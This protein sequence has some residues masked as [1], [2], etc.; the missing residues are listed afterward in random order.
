KAVP[1]A[2]ERG[3]GR[4]GRRR[5]LVRPGGP[6]LG[7]PRRARQGHVLPGLRGE[8]GLEPVA[9]A[10]PRRR[11]DRAPRGDQLLDHPAH[12]QA[13]HRGRGRRVHVQDRQRHGAA[14]PAH[15]RP[16]GWWRGLHPRAGAGRHREAHALRVVARQQ[17]ELS[18]PGSGSRRGPEVGAVG[19]QLGVDLGTTA[20]AA[21]VGRDG[22]TEVVNLGSRSA[23]VPAVVFARHDGVLTFGESAEAAGASEPAR[24]QRGLKRRFGDPAPVVVGD[25]VSTPE[26]IT[27]AMLRWVVGRVMEREGEAPRLTVV[28]H[29]AAWSRQRVDR[30]AEAARLAEA[31]AVLLATE[32]QAAALHVFGATLPEGALVATYD[33]GGSFETAV[34]RRTADGFELAGR[35]E[36]VEHLGGDEFDE[37]LLFHVATRAGVDLPEGVEQEP[38]VEAAF[39]GL[40]QQCVAAKEA[41]SSIEEAEVPV[42]LP[43]V[44]TSVTVTRAEFELMIRPALLETVAAFRRAVRSAGAEPADLVAVLLLGGCARIPLVATLLGAEVPNVVARAGDA[45]YAVSRGAARWS[46][47]EAERAADVVRGPGA[48]VLVGAGAGAGAA[49]A[50][51][52]ADAT[53]GGAA[54]PPLAPPP[55]GQRTRKRRWPLAAALLVV[56]L[57]P[58]GLW[59]ATRDGGSESAS[60]PVGAPAGDDGPSTSTTLPVVIPSGVGMVAIPGGAYP[61]GVAPGRVSELSPYHLDQF[62]VTGDQYAKFLQEVEG[63]ERP[64]GW[65]SRAAPVGLENHPVVGVS[66][67][68]A[69]AYCS[70]LGKRLPTEEEWEAAARGQDGRLYPWGADP[71]AV[72]LPLSGTHAVGSIPGTRSPLGVDDLVGNVWEWV[73]QPYDPVEGEAVVRRGGRNGLVRDGALDRQAVDPANRSVLSET[74][75]RC[76]AEVVDPDAPPGQFSSDIQVEQQ[77]PGTTA[78]TGP[79]SGLIDDSFEDDTSGWPREPNA[80]QQAKGIVVGYHG[81]TAYHVDLTQPSQSQLVLRGV[82]YIDTRLTLDTFTLRL[83]QPGS[84]RYGLV[85]RA[86]AHDRNRMGVASARE[87]NYYAFVIDP[88]RGVWEL[89][90]KDTLPFRTL[91]SGPLPPGTRIREEAN[92][93][94]LMV[95]LQGNELRMYIN[96]VPVGPAP[97]VMSANHSDGDVGFYVESMGASGVHVHVDRIRAEAL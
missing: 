67:L 90:H 83:G 42:L 12:H 85:F 70:A 48:A 8:P 88:G 66:W 34:L 76:S 47:E 54:L 65:D 55:M 13:A 73:G 51:A 36:R 91:E 84:Y 9:G 7:R 33:L 97:Y 35:P 29:P 92:P 16:Q 21:A 62:E 1:P 3:P 41:L 2:R 82:D 37:A 5:V 96:D 75:F 52:L 95:D 28:T 46:S 40:R 93:D 25:T 89:L 39:R 87:E 22:T 57:A 30:L 18:P 63:V 64:T 71:A 27:G 32:P 59:A 45:K 58:I 94:R 4:T 14:E 15:P 26:Q 17:A 44:D 11:R 60:A 86:H 77:E 81:P 6:G 23:A 56:V 43:G 53:A 79:T 72:A 78:S 38:H 80:D 61:M 68:W 69:D 20:V 19:Y 31:G 10:R 50:G 49:G 24:L 74:G